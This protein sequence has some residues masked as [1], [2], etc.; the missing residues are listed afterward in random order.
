M[1]NQL[2]ATERSIYN[3]YTDKSITKYSGSVQSNSTASDLLIASFVSVTR[4]VSHA[5]SES[6]NI[7]RSYLRHALGTSS[8]SAGNKAAFILDHIFP[9]LGQ[10]G[11]S[12]AVESLPERPKKRYCTFPSGTLIAYT[13]TEHL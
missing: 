7:S 10:S 4:G 11:F 2:E 8:I 1:Y 6:T 13:R 5:I 3:P 12:P 9:P